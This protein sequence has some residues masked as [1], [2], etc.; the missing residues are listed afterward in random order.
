MFI[1]AKKDAAVN[2]FTTSGP[3]VVAAVMRREADP[4]APPDSRP[5]TANVVKAVN[6]KRKGMR[7]ADPTDATFEVIT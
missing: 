3:A 2:M 7:P 6:R 1:Q 5:K 4:D